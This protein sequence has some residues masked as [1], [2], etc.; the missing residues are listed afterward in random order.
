MAI[1]YRRIWNWFRLEV[2]V[3][4]WRM[5]LFGFV[6]VIGLLPLITMNAYV[7][8][9]LTFAC[10]FAIF[11]ASWDLL[12][13]YVGQLSLGHCA[14]FGVGAYTSA[15]LNIHLKL[16]PVITIPCG[17]AMA[18]LAGLVIALPTMRLRGFYLSLVTM[19]FP[20]V[21]GGLIF[22]FPDV[23]G[24]EMGIYGVTRLAGSPLS[25]FYI[26]L[27]IMVLSLIVMWKLTDA[28][29]RFIRTGVIFFAIRE[30]E[31]A[32]R[33]S[34]IN[35]SLYRTFGF[36]FSGFFAGLAGALYAHVMRIAGPS[37]LEMLL[38]FDV[39]LW[40][41]FGGSTT[42]YGA[43]IAT[44]IL[45]PLMEIIRLHPIGEEFR[46]VFKACLLIVVITFMPHG[47]TRWIRDHIEE[48]C[49]RCK[50]INLWT[51]KY[52]RACRA[53]MKAERTG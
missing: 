39:I 6:L 16:P 37:T 24:G 36:C 26:S 41:I 44:F 48:D 42:I 40:A 43:M 4:P 49:P 52:C 13:G 3:I 33:A 19:A 38:S 45:Y 2:W 14:F 7:L 21:L 31:I 53:P 34:G 11:S 22:I 50:I 23:S 28:E 9:I 46:I 30:D 27:I 1:L 15:L 8:R 20:F 17:A 10:I 51:H 47:I 12:S 32:A 18:V 35:T 25:I 5:I 29:S